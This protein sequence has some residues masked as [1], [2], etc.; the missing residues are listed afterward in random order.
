MALSGT[1]RGARRRG[2]DKPYA[3]RRRRGGS[4]S[5]DVVGSKNVAGNNGHDDVRGR[6]GADWM[7][8]RGSRPRTKGNANMTAAA[9]NKRN[10]T[11]WDAKRRN[12]A[13]S[14]G[15]SLRPIKISSSGIMS[16]WKKPLGGLIRYYVHTR[17]HDRESPVDQRTAEEEIDRC[18]YRSGCSME[19]TKTMILESL[20]VTKDIQKG[21]IGISM[22][23]EKDCQMDDI[24]ISNK[25]NAGDSMDVSNADGDASS[26]F[27]ETIDG[28][29][30]KLKDVL[31]AGEG[32]AHSHQQ[33]TTIVVPEWAVGKGFFFEVKNHT[34][35][36]LSCELFLDGEKVAFN[37]P[38]LPSSTRTIRP[39]VVRYYERHRWILNGARRVKLAT[40]RPRSDGNNDIHVPI[41]PRYNGIRPDYEGKRVNSEKYPDPTVFG[42]E[43]T[44]GVQESRV[45][46]FE[47]RMNIGLAKLDFYYSSGTLKTT[48]YHPTSGRNQLFRGKVTAE[49][50]VDVM[51]NPRSHTGQGY[52]RR[53]NRPTGSE[54]NP[55][56]EEDDKFDRMSTWN[57]QT[58]EDTGMDDNG[59]SREHAQ[60]TY[61]AKDDKYD[62]K[63]QGHRNRFDQMNK[64][65]QSSDYAEWTKANKNEY[66]MIHA[67]FYLSI[68]KR[69][70]KAQPKSGGFKQRRRKQTTPL[71]LPE[72]ASVVDVKAAE[73]ATLGTKYQAMGPPQSISRSSVRMERINGL[74]DDKD[75]KG[76]PVFEKKLYYRAENIVSGHGCGDDDSDDMS[77]DQNEPVSNPP[78]DEYKTE[79]IEQVKQHHSELSVSVIDP[80]E[81]EQRLRNVKN[82]ICRSESI[83]DVDE[84]VKLFY[85]D[86]TRRQIVGH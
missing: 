7:K 59:A 70:Y 48:L 16:S 26:G 38:L 85:D 54:N 44:G 11:R 40:A 15:G 22:A 56:E 71:P 53:E 49:Q 66:A 3:H 25:I 36:N 57:T 9:G 29:G 78:L 6:V 62:F 74:T 79:K 75:W 83:E 1:E 14:S 10:R 45:E 46:F 28:K 43:F 76:E 82:K 55:E 2:G 69:T 64:L 13:P 8:R 51:K 47:K 12:E 37:A 34:P 41:A 19:D 27:S 52:R 60:S 67:K 58:G 32:P 73:N 42:W 24:P 84:T 5:A 68:P 50:Y 63:R 77:E 23:I 33:W 20:G 61:Y 81:A 39:D 86:L 65:Q 30:I 4:V 21:W 31:R 72:Q 35:L 17:M 80:D 18:Y